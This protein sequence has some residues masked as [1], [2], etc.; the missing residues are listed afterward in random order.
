M[1]GNLAKNLYKFGHTIKKLNTTAVSIPNALRVTYPNQ[2]NH[3]MDIESPLETFISTIAACETAILRSY[4]RKKGFKIGTVTWNKIE[5]S[6]DLVHWLEGGGPDNLLG[7]IT[8]DCDIESTLNQ[9]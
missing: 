9:N 4:A 6:Y 8:L 7:D 3:V 1:I 5:S 2:N